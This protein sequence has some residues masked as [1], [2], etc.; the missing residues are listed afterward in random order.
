MKTDDHIVHLPDLSFSRHCEK[1]FG[2]NRGIYNTIDEYFFNLGKSEIRNRRETMLLFLRYMERSYSRKVTGKIKVGRN[3][4]S[5][6]LNE[7][8]KN[9]S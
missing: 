8:I 4:L 2:I 7:F 6:R 3:G 1:E 5:S 9:G